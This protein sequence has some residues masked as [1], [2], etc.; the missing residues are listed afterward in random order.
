MTE[1]KMPPLTERQQ[2]IIRA[3]MKHF[4]WSQEEVVSYFIKAGKRDDKFKE[5][6]Q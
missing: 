3:M 6:Y 4:N 2:Y 5:E 1:V